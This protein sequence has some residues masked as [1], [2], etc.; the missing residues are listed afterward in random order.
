[1]SPLE[2]IAAETTYGLPR[3]RGDEPA[4]ANPFEEPCASA[5]HTRG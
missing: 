4:P 5:P 1:M 2:V 3:T